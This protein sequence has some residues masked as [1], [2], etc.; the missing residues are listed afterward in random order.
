[1]LL[2]SG[3]NPQQTNTKSKKPTDLISSQ[4]M[5]DIFNSHGIQHVAFQK[6]EI[7]I[8]SEELTV[9]RKKEKVPLRTNC[10]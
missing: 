7:K 4:E 2:S 8:C 1:M 10:F 5:S 6:K 3:A 9:S